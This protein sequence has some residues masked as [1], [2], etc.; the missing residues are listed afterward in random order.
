VNL[1]ICQVGSISFDP[2]PSANL[3]SVERGVWVYI[4]VKIRPQMLLCGFG[5]I[6]RHVIH[7]LVQLLWG[8]KKETRHIF[9]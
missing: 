1:G 2:N 4:Y 6:N 7:I 8:E 5:F 9:Y 3:V